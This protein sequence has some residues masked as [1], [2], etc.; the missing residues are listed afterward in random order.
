MLNLY[1]KAPPPLDKN[2]TKKQTKNTKLI[3]HFQVGECITVIGWAKHR[4][5]I[6]MIKA[7]IMTSLYPF[8]KPMTA[9]ITSKSL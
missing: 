9:V 5:N 6:A 8:Q 1:G 2:K 4:Q 7:P 3:N